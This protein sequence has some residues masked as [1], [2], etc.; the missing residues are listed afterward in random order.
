VKGL[1]STKSAKEILKNTAASN[2]KWIKSKKKK[3]K[4]FKLKIAFFGAINP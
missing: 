3:K 4:P 1:K 2:D